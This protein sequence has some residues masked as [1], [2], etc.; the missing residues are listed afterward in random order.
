MLHHAFFAC[1]R[2][3]WKQLSEQKRLAG[4]E[5]TN[6]F[7]QTQ[8]RARQGWIARNVAPRWHPNTCGFG[9][10]IDNAFDAA[11]SDFRKEMFEDESEFLNARREPNLHFP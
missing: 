9:M 4:T 10:T 1:L 7:P 2:E 3:A 5:A 11:L 8:V 6:L